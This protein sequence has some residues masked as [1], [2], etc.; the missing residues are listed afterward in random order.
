MNRFEFDYDT[1]E[2]KKV[3]DK[4]E[5]GLELDLTQYTEFQE[6]NCK[7]ELQAV[8]IHTGTA[9]GGHY[10]AYIRDL[11]DEGNFSLLLEQ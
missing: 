11:M 2:R 8:M 9:H 10:H 4:F 1:F 3:N 5:F 7:Y 6:D